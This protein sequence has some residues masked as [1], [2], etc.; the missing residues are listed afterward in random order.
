MSPESATDRDPQPATDADLELALMGRRWQFCRGNGSV[1]A[2]SIRLL[3]GGGIAPRLHSN[4]HAWRVHQGVLEFTNPQGAVSCRFDTVIRDAR[5][6]MT[7]QGAFRWAS[8]VQHVLKELG[9]FI[10]RGPPNSSPRVALLVRTHRVN[11]KLFDLLDLLNQ[12]R[13]YDLFVTA[14][15]TRGPLD[16]G[17]YTKLPHTV[18]TCRQFGLSTQHLN[19]LW[20]C[21]D[22]P[23]YFAA[24][25]AP[26]YDYYAMIEYDVDLVRKSPLFLEGLIARLPDSGAEFIAEGSNP[27]WSGWCWAEA[28]RRTFP[29]VYTSG[30]FAFVIAS[31]DALLH[32]LEARRQEALTGV[33]DNDIIHCE[34]FCVSSLMASG[35]P[36]ASINSIIDN[37][38][39][40]SSYHPGIPDNLDGEFLLNHYRL[41]QPTVEIVHPVYDLRDYLPKQYQKALQN[42]QLG[43]FLE[44]LTKIDQTREQDARWVAEFRQRALE[45]AGTG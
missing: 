6:V 12:S 35:Y 30:I 36:C 11:E 22:Y 40:G 4:E 14:D 26:G 16:V 25:E 44:I 20:H 32:L 37:A 15:E 27:A 8:G 24:A 13:R 45:Q 9:T 19:I 7:L 17:G 29:R 33:V 31:R 28:A 38:V 21:G 34:A 43:R 1:I 18:D 5:G 39:H 2:R 10:R 23:L 41:E 3:R 42:N